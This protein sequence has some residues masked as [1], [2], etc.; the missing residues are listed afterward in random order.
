MGREPHCSILSPTSF[1]V[2]IVQPKVQVL[3]KKTI[4]FHVRQSTTQEVHHDTM[5]FQTDTLHVPTK[6][7]LVM[8]NTHVPLQGLNN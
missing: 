2:S 5:H 6:G 4:N 7:V 1:C 8:H 3:Q